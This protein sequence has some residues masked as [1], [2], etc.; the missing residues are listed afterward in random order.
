M[1]NGIELNF[2]LP[3]PVAGWDDSPYM[4]K[5]KALNQIW[6]HW[7]GYQGE[8][9]LANTVAALPNESVLRWGGAIGTNDNDFISANRASGQVMMWDSKYSSAVDSVKSSPTFTPGSN[10]LSSVIDQ[11]RLAVENSAQSDSVKATALGNI[12][13]G[14]FVTNTVGSGGY[15]NSVQ[16]RFCNGSPC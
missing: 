11:A 1:F 4:L 3:P 5:G 10:R 12:N 9:N 7:T 6:A 2:S 15:K 13:R 8:I 14:N 16:V